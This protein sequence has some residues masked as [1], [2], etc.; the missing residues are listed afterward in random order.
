[1]SFIKS[2]TIKSLLV[3]KISTR[4]TVP[5]FQRNLKWISG[6]LELGPSK[7]YPLLG[8]NSLFEGIRNF[9]IN[10]EQDLMIVSRN[11]YIRLNVKS[12]EMAQVWMIKSDCNCFQKELICRLL[13]IDSKFQS[14][15][16]ALKVQYSQ[17]HWDLL[18]KLL[19]FLKYI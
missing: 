2:Y 12:N 15:P 10:L 16:R 11:T 18:P 1:M 9:T 14:D 6:F 4:T 8:K 7:P 3:I 5:Q 17:N 13:K 19:V